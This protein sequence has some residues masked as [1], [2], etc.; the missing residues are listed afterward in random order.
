MFQPLFFHIL[1]FGLLLFALL[2]FM[3]LIFLFFCL[4][5]VV[6]VV[7]VIVVVVEEISFMNSTLS[8]LVFHVPQTKYL[9]DTTIANQNTGWSCFIK[10]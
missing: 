3:S 10:S 9:D 1:W 8:Y 4:F 6:V 2:V 5:V 7:V